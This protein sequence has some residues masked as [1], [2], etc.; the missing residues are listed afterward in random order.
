MGDDHWKGDLPDEQNDMEACAALDL[1][2]GCRCHVELSVS[3]PDG[4]LP[5]DDARRGMAVIL[6]DV[7]ESMWLAICRKRD[8]AAIEGEV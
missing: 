8:E 1:P 6:G 4:W 3:Y 2:G 7:T 5:P